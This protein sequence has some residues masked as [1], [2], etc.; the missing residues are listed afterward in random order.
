MKQ[1]LMGLMCASAGSTNFKRFVRHEIT[2]AERQLVISAVTAKLKDPDCAKFGDMQAGVTSTW[3]ISVCGQVNSKNSFGGYVGMTP[4]YAV[5]TDGKISPSGVGIA[6]GT[7][8]YSNVDNMLVEGVC[9]NVHEA[10]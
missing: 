2:P 8:T 4:F 9:K 6:G 1:L 3:A 10:V 5:I 7:G